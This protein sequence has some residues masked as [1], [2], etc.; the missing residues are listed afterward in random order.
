MADRERERENVWLYVFFQPEVLNPNDFT[1]SYYLNLKKYE[2]N[3]SSRIKC[4]EIFQQHSFNRRP[5][6]ITKWH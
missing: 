5:I 2:K 4:R 1:I 3:R 6:D